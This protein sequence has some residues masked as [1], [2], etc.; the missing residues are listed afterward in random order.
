M[1]M[2][3]SAPI[4]LTIVILTVIT[5][6][7]A[8]YN[9]T[10]R[11]SLLFNP[12]FVSEKNQIYRL[13]TSGLIHAD[14][15]HLGFNMYVLWNFGAILE[16]N[17]D[18]L[19]PI[20]FLAIYIASLPLSALPSLIR[21]KNNIHYNALG[22]SGAVSAIVMSFV[23]F[24]PRA[25]L[26]LLFIPIGFEAWIFA[27]LYLAY[28]FYMTFKG[29]DNIG[30]DAHLWGGLGGIIMTLVMRPELAGQFISQF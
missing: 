25:K 12:Y 3:F 18:L 14:W 10:L 19:G 26:S 2:A 27:L 30:H 16:A 7:R 1:P 21:H 6:I 17:N 8:F 15:L 23:L 20:G 22:A 28:S 5:S 24:A 29:N 9:P 13:F 11:N 4:T